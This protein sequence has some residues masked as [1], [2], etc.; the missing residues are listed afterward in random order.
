MR[1]LDAA[2]GWENPASVYPPYDIEKADDDSYRIT[3]AVPGYDID[4][5]TVEQ[6]EN[7]LVVSGRREAEAPDGAYLYRGIGAP[8]FE[9]SFQ[10]A[11]YVRVEDAGLENGLLRIDLH[12]ELPDEL[13][14]RR[15]EI[16]TGPRKF[17]GKAK[18]LIQGTKKAA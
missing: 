14:P 15:I 4:D 2:T 16:A 8:A 6:R 17:A 5:L 3:L 18:K 1:L 10:L 13:K 11:D 9:H 7:T 12:R